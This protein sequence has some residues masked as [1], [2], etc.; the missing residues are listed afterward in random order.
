MA[1]MANLIDFNGWKEV[2]VVFLDDDYGRNG[3]SVLSDELENRRL[4]ISHKLAL[5]IHFDLDEITKLL[6]QSKVFNPRV[7][8]VHINPDPRLRIFSVAHK[9]QMMTSE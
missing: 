6:N 3:V 1:A 9:L 7:F 2:I 5:S 8:V 4:K